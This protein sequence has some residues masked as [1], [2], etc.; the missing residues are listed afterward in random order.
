MNCWSELFDVI[1]HTRTQYRR[2][3]TDTLYKVEIFHKILNS[4]LSRRHKLHSMRLQHMAKAHFLCYQV[5]W[6]QAFL[7]IGTLAEK[8]KVQVRRSY[9]V[10]PS[11]SNAISMMA[12]SLARQTTEF[13]ASTS[14]FQTWASVTLVSLFLP[15]VT[16]CCFLIVFFGGGSQ[17]TV[18]L[19]SNP[20]ICAVNTLY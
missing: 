13:V 10:S 17:S 12:P 5:R 6:F 15:A 4:S 16:F 2:C 1:W 20:I 18:W 14:W 19:L 9:S 7:E 11:I 3:S 8:R